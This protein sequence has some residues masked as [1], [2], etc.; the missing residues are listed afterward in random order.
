MLDTDKNKIKRIHLIRHGKTEAN[1]DHLYCG[2]TDLFL[3]QNGREEIIG[4]SEDDIYPKAKIF[5]ASSMR[6][7]IQTLSL[8]YGHVEYITIPELGEFDFGRFE[9]H[10]YEQL[11]DACDYQRWINDLSGTVACPDGECRADFEERVKKGLCLIK[12]TADSSEGDIAAV[13]HGGV[14]VTIMQT[15]FP[16]KKNFYEWQPAPGRGYT[17]TISDGSFSGYQRI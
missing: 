8:I 3:S 14:I 15:L 2:K 9:M 1:R 4:F 11:K 7:A 6:R 13:T 16:G 5:I 17:I 10:S 12:E